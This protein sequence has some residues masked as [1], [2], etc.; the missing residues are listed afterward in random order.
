[1]FPAKP[2]DLWLQYGIS[3]K[4]VPANQ[5]VI[6]IILK[7]FSYHLKKGKPDILGWLQGFVTKGIQ[8]R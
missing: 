2:F 6:A 7:C 4:M 8:R 1:M 5:S 3:N